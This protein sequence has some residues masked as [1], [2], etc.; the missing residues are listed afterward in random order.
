MH[1]KMFALAKPYGRDLIC[2]AAASLTLIAAGVVAPWLLRDLTTRL[3]LRDGVTGGLLLAYALW[4]AAAYSVQAVCRY[5]SSYLSHRA[6]WRLVPRLRADLY[7]HM[8]YLSPG[9]YSTRQTGQLMSRVVNDTEKL[10]QLIAHVIPELATSVLTFI[11][12][13]ILLLMI[14]PLLTLFVLL[15]V[16]LLGAGGWLFAKKIRPMFSKAQSLLGDFSGAL[17]E[18]IS[19]VKEIQSFGRQ[20]GEYRKISGLASAYSAEILRALR[21]SALFHSSTGLLTSAGTLIVVSLGGW[22]AMQGRLAIGD[23]LA[24]V[25]Y[26]NM[27]YQPIQA[28]AQLL[29][30]FQSAYAG[31]ERVFEIMDAASDVRDEP[32]ARPLQAV[33]GDIRLESV[34]FNY[35]SG[36]QHVLRLVDLEIPAKS[37]V[38]FV[39]PT[40]VGKTTVINLLMRFY[41]PTGGRVLIDGHDIRHVTLESLRR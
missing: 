33:K 20:G 15:P 29:E 30:N 2:A 13:L 1:R 10:E 21:T 34:S 35:E 31:A 41:D 24:F 6:A 25:L 36:D 12:V 19:G 39:G 23:I 9:F 11:A 8:Q 38:A 4:L 5:F 37:F 32:G 40:G 28:M 18:N 7:N 22:L 17:Q 16:P 27:L 3:E 14:N 26:L